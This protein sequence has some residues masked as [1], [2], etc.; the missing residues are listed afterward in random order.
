[1][2]LT[3]NNLFLYMAI[4]TVVSLLLIVMTHSKKDKK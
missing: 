4:F 2:T 3:I 1:M